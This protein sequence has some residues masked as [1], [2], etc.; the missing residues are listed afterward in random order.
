MNFTPI[1]VRN[2]FPKSV[3]KNVEKV[4]IY[5]ASQRDIRRQRMM[6]EVR[7]VVANLL[8]SV[9][10]TITLLPSMWIKKKKRKIKVMRKM[11]RKVR[12]K[13]QLF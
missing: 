5:A 10:V 11:I 1:C 12:M 9:N 6:M 4:S 2:H 13:I 8:K 3:T 7:K